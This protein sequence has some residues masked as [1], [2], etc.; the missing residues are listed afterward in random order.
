MLG[1]VLK[2]VRVFG[3]S[4]IIVLL[5]P[6]NVA[7]AEEA[8]KVTQVSRFAVV[9]KRLVVVALAEI[10]VASPQ[11]ESGIGGLEAD[12]IREVANC[13]VGIA[14]IEERSPAIAQSGGAIGPW[15]VSVLDDR[16]A[17]R[18]LLIPGRAGDS[19]ATGRI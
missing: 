11:I 4:E 10:R 9:L 16:R 13:A 14:A 7:A 1:I 18:D 3:D 5:D 6:V 17:A 2:R 19:I 8:L 15:P 12:R